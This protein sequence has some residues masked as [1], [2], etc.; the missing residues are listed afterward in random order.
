MAATEKLRSLVITDTAGKAKA[1][2]KFLGKSYVVISTDGFLKNIPKSRIGID[3]ENYSPDY[4][5]IRGK[6]DIL[7]ELKRESLKARK[8]FFATNL[9]GAGEFL[10]QQCCEI[11]G[12]NEKSRCRLVIDEMTKETVKKSFDNARAV[13][14]NLVAAFQARQ[15]IDK[16]VSHR[17]GE[18]LDCKIYRGVKVGRF[19]AM[20]LNLISLVTETKTEGDFQFEEKFTPAVLQEISLGNL[21]FSSTKTI[22]TLEQLYEG[23]N[24]DKAGFAGL[25]KFPRTEKIELASENREPE[26]VKD[27]LTGS[28]YKLY[29]LIYKKIHGGEIVN[30][31]YLNASCTEQSLMATF[32]T[33]KIDWTDFYS[34]GIN[35]LLKRGYIELGDGVF[36][37][38]DLGQQ[39][40]DSVNEFFGELFSVE[41]YNKLSEQISQVAQGKA[42]K[43][44]VIKNYLNEFEKC[45]DSAMK[46]LGENPQP[47]AQ[48]V[49]ESDEVCEKCGRPMVIRRGRYGQFLTCSGYPECKNAKPLLNY[50][51]QKCPKC[52]GRLTKRN[53]KG[54][55][56]FYSCENFQTCD[57]NTWD[58]PL[59]TVCKFC[60]STRF[61]HRFKDRAP[62]PYCGN[63][64]CESR[65][66]HPMN[67]IIEDAQKRYEA[68]KLRKAKNLNKKVDQE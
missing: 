8:V 28:Q 68:R 35:S 4:I 30:K 47:K 10:A 53:F 63:A 24:F 38:T 56:I 11:F 49:I 27:F 46:S 67:K 31:F 60:G 17:I 45:F 37:I 62:M 41:S 6:G 44:S 58:E 25:I 12:V 21:N 66:D 20:L 64:N 13:D 22:L 52:G 18:Y 55:R 39:V 40:L 34:V 19:R 36:K 1:L 16:F 7:K 57:F 9:D 48:P 43:L 51:E 14:E 2:K 26:S 3:V 65:K 50:L 59:E 42:E 33:L 54:G 15:I 32:D 23:F 61:L 29:E 5:T